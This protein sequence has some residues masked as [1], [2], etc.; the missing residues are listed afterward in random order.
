MKNMT[1]LLGNWN[2]KKGK[3]QQKFALLTNSDLL[4]IEGK[5]NEMMGRLQEKLG[6]TKKEI[7]KI[8]SEL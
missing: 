2:E 1:E 5:E 6:K 4:F 7:N 8:I 3:L